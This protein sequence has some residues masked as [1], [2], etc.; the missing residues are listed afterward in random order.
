M[1]WGAPTVR[2]AP[3]VPWAKAG[4]DQ[5]TLYIAR[6]CS[7]VRDDVKHRRPE[8]LHDE[9]YTLSVDTNKIIQGGPFWEVAVVLPTLSVLTL[10]A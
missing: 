9:G 5:N 6:C 7:F 4:P 3:V 1:Y 8:T 2:F 10:A